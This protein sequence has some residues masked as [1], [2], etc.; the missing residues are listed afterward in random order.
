[1]SQTILCPCPPLLAAVSFGHILFLHFFPL[2]FRLSASSRSVPYFFVVSFPTRLSCLFRFPSPVS[3]SRPKLPWPRINAGELWKSAAKRIC[4]GKRSRDLRLGSSSYRPL[5]P[6]FLLALASVPLADFFCLV[7][8]FPPVYADRGKPAVIPRNW[9][10]FARVRRHEFFS[11]SEKTYITRG[12]TRGFDWI[13]ALGVINPGA[14][15]S[16]LIEL[17]SMRSTTD[18]FRLSRFTR[19]GRLCEINEVVDG[20]AIET[21]VIHGG[22]LIAV[23]VSSF[24]PNVHSCGFIHAAWHSHFRAMR[25]IYVTVTVVFLGLRSCTWSVLPLLLMLSSRNCGIIMERKSEIG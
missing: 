23:H 1:M 4:N 11:V 13:F 12:D 10:L 25:N 9:D 8:A 17:W 2:R 18:G 5:P 20:F 15:R 3:L 21:W 19:F 16:R 6:S 14:I 7:S 22:T 24:A